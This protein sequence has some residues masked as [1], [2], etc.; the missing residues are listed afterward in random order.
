MNVVYSELKKSSK[1]NI[2]LTVSRVEYEVWKDLDFCKYHY[3]NEDMPKYC[4]SVLFS[5]NNEP[6]AF[7]GVNKIPIFGNNNSYFISRLVILP[8]FQGLGLSTKILNFIGGVVKNINGIVYIKTIHPNIG[9]S[10]E[11]NKLWEATSS[12]GVLT[13]ENSYIDKKGIKHNLKPRISFSYKY[14]GIKINSYD[15]LFDKIDRLRERKLNKGYKQL[16]LF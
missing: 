2:K 11:K 9:R 5:W 13:K 12:N 1:P 15:E 7:C 16:E 14:N 3:M 6:V 8:D 10:L 4:R